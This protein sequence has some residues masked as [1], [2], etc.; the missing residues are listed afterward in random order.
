MNL[1]VRKQ[2]E[3]SI[4]VLWWDQPVDRDALNKMHAFMR[5]DLHTLT[6]KLAVLKLMKVGEGIK[7]FG[8]RIT[9]TDFVIPMDEI[10]YG[11]KTK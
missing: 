7:G 9:E 2:D 4:T 11:T 10:L 8:S 3:G 5:H 6:G 1:C